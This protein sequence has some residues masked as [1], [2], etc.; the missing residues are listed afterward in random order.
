MLQLRGLLTAESCTIDQDALPGAVNV[1][2]VMIF[3]YYIQ[4]FNHFNNRLTYQYMNPRIIKKYRSFILFAL[5]PRLRST[6]SVVRDHLA[7]Q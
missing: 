2:V 6:D 4:I 3:A 7:E 5:P 1:F